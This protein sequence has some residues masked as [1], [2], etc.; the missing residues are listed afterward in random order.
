MLREYR[1]IFGDVVALLAIPSVLVALHFFLPDAIRSQLMFTYGESG[2]VAAWTS[3]YLHAS[4]AHLYQN[5]S[6][7]AIGA[8]F[9]YYLYAAY[10]QQRR[11]F[12][13]TVAVLL[14]VTPVITTVVDYAVLYR[15]VGLLATGATSQGFSG[16]VSALGGMLLAAIG[17]FV[18]DEYDAMTS[19]HTVLLIFLIALGFLTAVNGILT[20]TVAGLLIVGVGL[21][22]TQYLSLYDLQQPSQLRVQVEQHAVNIVQV[23]AYG[24][25]VCIFIYLILPIEVVQAGNFVNILAHTVGFVVGHI[26]AWVVGIK[27]V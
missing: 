7:Y 4:N 21:L 10:L 8:G 19:A 9:T 26:T 23:A 25:V 15:Y 12:W 6:G 3:A 20:S 13:I 11:R 24:A 5:L 14:A 2:I 16:I 27:S 18:A 17:F 1:S 22:S